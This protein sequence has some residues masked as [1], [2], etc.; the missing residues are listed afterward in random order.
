MAF[1]VESA[2]DFF[3]SKL[4]S[5]VGL[6]P[7]SAPLLE[8]PAQ[9]HFALRLRCAFFLSPPAVKEDNRSSFVP[10]FS[11]SES[12][13]CPPPLTWA[14][15]STTPHSFVLQRTSLIRS[16]LAGRSQPFTYN[17]PF[18]APCVKWTQMSRKKKYPRRRRREKLLPPFPQVFKKHLSSIKAPSKR[19]SSSPAAH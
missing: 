5:S 17:P 18:V 8:S 19:L 9:L 14:T 10:P 2:C 4:N 7:R 3:F 11:T 16:C 6:V 15:I 1:D 12:L 13:F